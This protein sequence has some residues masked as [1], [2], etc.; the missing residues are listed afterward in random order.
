MNGSNIRKGCKPLQLISPLNT[1]CL[2]ECLFEK[3][4]QFYF[5]LKSYQDTKIAKYF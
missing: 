3:V 4:N 1:D 2:F 5:S